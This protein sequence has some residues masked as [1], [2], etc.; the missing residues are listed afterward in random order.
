MLRILVGLCALC[1]FNVLAHADVFYFRMKSDYKYQVRV[2]FY[3]QDRK[4][5]W[6]G[7]NEVY[8]LD[9][10]AEHKFRVDCRTGERI[11]YGAWDAANPRIHW[12][13]GRDGKDSCT[14]CCFRCNGGESRLI[15]LGR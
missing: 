2:E 7:H 5:V 1:A 14:G 13:A 12:G 10:S 9:D 4:I 8:K 3:S 6:P 11:C 15:N